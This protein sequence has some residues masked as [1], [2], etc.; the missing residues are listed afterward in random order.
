MTSI[1]YKQTEEHKRNIGLS[2]LGKSPSEETKQKLSS[3][4]KKIPHSEEWSRNVRLGLQNMTEANKIKRNIASGLARLGNHPSNETRHRQSQ[5][6]LASWQSPEY[7][8]MQMEARVNR[9]Y[10]FADTS[11]ELALQNGLTNLGIEFETQKPIVG[12]PD[13]FIE[14]NVCIFA[15]GD[16]WHR[17]P[18]RRG[19]DAQVNSVL[20]SRGYKVLRF[21]E[22][23]IHENLEMCLDRIFVEV[24]P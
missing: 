23:E 22:Y 6:M 18:K 5:N 13:I 15:D 20:L 4:L 9:E 24:M 10:P 21:W 2:L 3:I 12:M 11:I 14:P 1:G 7:I 19:R 16:Y 17:R 8:Q